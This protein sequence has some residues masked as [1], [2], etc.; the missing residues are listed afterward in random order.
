MFEEL[1]KLMQPELDAELNTAVDA[2]V[3]AAVDAAVANNTD[4]VK[5]QTVDNVVKKL[6]ISL[7]EACEVLGITIEK[8][9][10]IKAGT[11]QNELN[12][13]E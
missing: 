5:V 7:M 4:I 8:Y 6:G 9:E 3:S 13:T 10:E 12:K 11:A 1:R 2:A